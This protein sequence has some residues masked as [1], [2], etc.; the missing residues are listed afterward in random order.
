MVAGFLT[1]DGPIG[2]V[3]NLQS[4]NEGQVRTIT[5]AGTG[6]IDSVAPFKA[7]FYVDPGFAGP[8]FTGSA[9]N[10]FT[11]IAAAFAAAAAQ[12]LAGAVILLPP[13]TTITENI[14]IPTS[15][16]SWE[17]TAIEQFGSFS[18][19]LTGAIDVSTTPA[20]VSEVAF[21]NLDIEHNIVG[22][23]TGGPNTFGFCRF[24]NCFVDG[25]VTLTKSGQAEWICEFFGQGVVAQIASEVA[26]T[27]AV[28]CSGQVFGYDISFGGDVAWGV[29]N[30]EFSGCGFAGGSLTANAT[31]R[32]TFKACDVQSVPLV[33]TCNVG[34][35]IFVVDG[36]TAASMQ[37]AGTTTAGAGVV[38]VETYVSNGSQVRATLAG[39]SGVYTL[40]NR[41]PASQC[42][43][44]VALTL[45]VPGTAGAIQAVVTYT[46]LLGVSRS[47]NVGGALAVNGSAGDIVSGQLSFSQ[48]GAQNVQ[49]ALT[50][51]ITPG[52]LSYQ[53]DVACTFVS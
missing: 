29:S 22:L 9:A 13:Q 28:S 21:T 47:R 8:I 26:V 23:I 24:N 39:N 5:S 14:T 10:P 1:Y 30:S 12:G 25:T 49:L 48:N 2:S 41:Y 15:G 38:N 35:A 51:V 20:G 6:G 19:T 43:V 52:P 3:V 46:D 50:G 4:T 17:L 44:N 33:L 31:S 16:G 37:H 18:T 40:S 53:A 45:L 36:Y 27:G 32:T 42:V 11:T 34:Q 7:Q